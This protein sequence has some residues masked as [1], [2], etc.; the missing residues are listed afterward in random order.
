MT[1]AI[2]LSL[3]QFA[4]SDVEILKR[5]FNQWRSN[6]LSN[7]Q[8]EERLGDVVWNWM[9]ENLSDDP[10]N[11]VTRL[12]PLRRNDITIENFAQKCNQECIAKFFQEKNNVQITISTEEFIAIFKSMSQIKETTFDKIR[13]LNK[14]LNEIDPGRQIRIILVSHTNLCHTEYIIEQLQ[15]EIPEL[16]L[17]NFKQDES[18]EPPTARVLLITSMFT[19][20]VEHPDILKKGLVYLAAH[21]LEITE[22]VSCLK[23][24]D[25]NEAFPYKKPDTD[26]PNILEFLPS[27]LQSNNSAQCKL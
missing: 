11:K 23:T 27:L 12:D 10:K 2:I 22:G 14:A 17:N 21:G 15:T 24:I 26:F 6:Q 20:G 8:N 5:G 16:T 25:K 1:T 18:L 13:S 19:G 4:D 7:Q 3:G 9:S